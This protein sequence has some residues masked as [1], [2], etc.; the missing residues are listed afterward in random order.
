[1][2]TETPAAVS[3]SPELIQYSSWTNVNSEWQVTGTASILYG[4]LNL[5]AGTTITKAIT[6]L[7]VGKKYGL[8][9]KGYSTHSMKKGVGTTANGYEQVSHS[10][11]GVGWLL[12]DATSTTHYVTIQ[13]TTGVSQ[14]FTGINLYNVEMTSGH[15]MVSLFYKGAATAGQH[16]EPAAGAYTSVSGTRSYIE[17]TASF[18]SN[19]Y[20][21]I[22]PYQGTSLTFFT[23]KT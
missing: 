19:V 1:M 3:T 22:N 7:T 14:R 8:Y 5:S 20:T 10:G 2:L 23:E 4:A 15:S 21:G 12:F 16:Q 9:Y 6:G 17:P 13:N 18:V 11:T